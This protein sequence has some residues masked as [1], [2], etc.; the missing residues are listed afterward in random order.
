[1]NNKELLKVAVGNIQDELKRILLV[2]E[3]QLIEKSV[4]YDEFKAKLIGEFNT[5]LRGFKAKIRQLTEENRSLKAKIT[6]L[7]ERTLAPEL[8]FHENIPFLAPPEKR[9]HNSQPLEEVSPNKQRKR[10]LPSKKKQTITSSQFNHLPTQYSDSSPDKATLN[11][12]PVKATFVSLNEDDHRV[13]GDS[14]DEFEPLDGG[15]AHPQHYTA[16]QRI[17]FMRSFLRAKL[18]DE[19]YKVELSKNPITEKPWKLHD[20]RPNSAWR[21]PKLL[22]PHLGMMTK[23]QEQNYEHFFEQAGFGRAGK[24]PQWDSEINPT[25]SQAD[26]AH[27]DRSQV[28]DKYSLPTGYMVGLFPNT[29][30]AE[31]RKKEAEEGEI[32][33]IQRRLASAMLSP[34]EEFI[35]YEDVLNTYVGQHRYA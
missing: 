21:R 8:K 19:K 30:E 15:P 16:L 25:L 13:V 17:E 2:A 7:E 29:Q 26:D 20:F 5:K 35:F 1:M 27:F 23:A 14:Q 12:S 3:L 18:S 32:K 4:E 9:K 10:D 34:P 28:M 11:S 22:N 31:D 24:G 6:V 33:R